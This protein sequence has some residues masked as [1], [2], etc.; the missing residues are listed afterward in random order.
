MNIKRI[1]L[2]YAASTPTHPLALKEMLPFFGKKFGNP[3]SI[4]HSFGKEA[5][6]AV[7][8]S[9]VK[10]AKILNCSPEEIIFTSCATESNNLALKGIAE[11]YC[12]KYQKCGEIIISSVEH[13]SILETAEHLEKSGWILKK[14]KVD[15]CGVID[16]NDLE[17]S[18]NEN[19]VLVSIMYVNNEVGA[20]EPIEE[21]VKIVKK[22]NQNA[23]VHTDAVQAAQQLSLDVKKLGIDLLSLTGHKFYAP[24]G[25]GLLYVKKGIQIVAQQNGGGQENKRRGGTE[26]VAFIVGMAKALELARVGAQKET[27]R[28][29]YLRDKLI[30]G[31]LKNIPAVELTGPTKNRLAHIASFVFKYIEGEA[32]L[33][34][35]DEKGIAASSGSACTSGDLE[36]S[37]VLLAMG[38]PAEIAHGSIRF[39]FS[40]QTTEKDIDYV[41]KVLPGIIKDLRK[42]SPL[43]P[44]NLS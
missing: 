43:T 12:A 42:I 35:L 36:P 34:K 32:I 21:I 38:Y 29:T 4:Y 16:L 8:K 13:H 9:R 27:K 2:D 37:H 17:N 1:Y 28:L 14:L 23:I 19:T 26:N 44:S 30:K 15:K 39:S 18:V 25:I 7:E 5:K 20:I 41:L 22:K 31:V 3:S 10:V 11:A 40:R 6:I 33:L 24:K